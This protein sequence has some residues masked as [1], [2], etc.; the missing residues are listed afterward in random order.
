VSLR[1]STERTSIQA[2]WPITPVNDGFYSARSALGIFVLPDTNNRPPRQPK[3]TICVDI[4]TPIF[5]KFCA[6]PR[7]VC[8]GHGSVM[9]TTMPKASIHKH[10]NA[11]GNK[12]DVG[13]TSRSGQK[14]AV[15]SE[16]Q[17]QLVKRRPQI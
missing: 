7:P 5:R 13:R 4:T 14:T 16:S 10:G 17:S 2:R 3:S 6:P 15:Q 9:R 8:L 12:Y 1:E 11:L